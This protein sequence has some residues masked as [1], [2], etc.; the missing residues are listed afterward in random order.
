MLP[1]GYSWEMGGHYIQQKAAFRSF[2]LV[3]IVAVLLVYIMLASSSA[4]WCCRC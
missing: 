4:R 2:A 3:M 1:P